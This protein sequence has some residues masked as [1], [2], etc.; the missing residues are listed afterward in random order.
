MG[1]EWGR[2]G[3]GAEGSKQEEERDRESIKTRQVETWT[4]RPPS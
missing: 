2:G 3:G 1:G 4:S